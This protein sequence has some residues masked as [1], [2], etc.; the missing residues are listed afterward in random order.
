MTPVRSHPGKTLLCS[1]LIVQILVFCTNRFQLNVHASES[2]GVGSAQ[3]AALSSENAPENGETTEKPSDCLAALENAVSQA[4]AG[5]RRSW[6]RRILPRRE[7]KS[8]RSRKM[9][10]AG[11]TKLSDIFSQKVRVVLPGGA[12]V[13]RPAITKA[14]SL[15]FNN[16]WNDLL[17]GKVGLEGWRLA[18]SFKI[19]M[20][21]KYGSIYP[22]FTAD[23]LEGTF[24]GSNVKVRDVLEYYLEQYFSDPKNEGKL[25]LVLNMAPSDLREAVVRRGKRAAGMLAGAIGIDVLFGVAG[26]F[27]P[28]G[29]V[30]WSK[31]MTNSWWSW[32]LGSFDRSQKDKALKEIER[33]TE[34][35]S[36]Y[37]FADLPP[38]EAE[39]YWIGAYGFHH[40]YAEQ[41]KVLNKLNQAPSFNPAGPPIV[42]APSADSKA[43][44]ETSLDSAF[45]NYQVAQQ[46]LANPVADPTSSKNPMELKRKYD[47]AVLNFAQML[48]HWEY[49]QLRK[50]PADKA[51]ASGGPDGTETALHSSEVATAKEVQAEFDL[52]TKMTYL[53]RPGDTPFKDFT[54]EFIRAI[55]G[56]R[57]GKSGSSA[58]GSQPSTNNAAAFFSFMSHN[59]HVK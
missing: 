52:L 16:L 53:T 56:S 39:T 37:D 31:N 33:I 22:P 34:K 4:S 3:Y 54:D 12:S 28:N 47:D 40:Q 7:L 32:L 59:Q 10:E 43:S 14:E 6:F 11:R 29:I 8:F 18:S 26:N 27:G 55:E 51:A 48:A 15:K 44:A 57:H 45:K 30:A 50:T 13:D 25:T 1:L 21:A 2:E 35:L 23:S 36:T 41:F 42:P 58:S 17:E 5:S 38:Q 49:A 9:F 24:G 19:W 46:A 20:R